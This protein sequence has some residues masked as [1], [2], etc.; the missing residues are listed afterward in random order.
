MQLILSDWWNI[1][2][3]NDFHVIAVAM[4]MRM[5]NVVTAVDPTITYALKSFNNRG[6][7]CSEGSVQSSFDSNRLH[8]KLLVNAIAPNNMRT[9]ESGVKK[10]IRAIDTNYCTRQHRRHKMPK[11][12]WRRRPNNVRTNLERLRMTFTANA[13]VF[14]SASCPLYYN[15]NKTRYIFPFLR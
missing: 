6:I 12:A 8:V 13:N 11:I 2:L 5:R 7:Q 4:C 3:I 10:K 15:M 9:R 1:K 14:Q